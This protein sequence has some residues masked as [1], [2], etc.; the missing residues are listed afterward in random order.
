MATRTEDIVD[1]V[2][3]RF[4]DIRDSTAGALS[5]DDAPS[6]RELGRVRRSL[7]DVEGRLASRLD[8]LGTQQSELASE[9][10]SSNK[11]TT[12]P[13]KVFWMLIGG[14]AAALGTYLADPDRGA[15]RRQTLA[16]EARTRANR[17]SEQ[18]RQTATAATDEVKQRA[19]GLAE[20]AKSTATEVADDTRERAAHGAEVASGKAEGA[21]NQAGSDDVPED[22]VLLEQRVKSQVLGHR[23]DVDDVV[24][25]IGK[26]GQVILKGVVPDEQSKA[27]LVAAIGDVNGVTDVQSELS[28][29]N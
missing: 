12:F 6:L 16:D 2:A 9:V 26:P 5:S 15:Q 20:D 14:A 25:V 27:S 23:G 17:A 11:S 21:L 18:A 22:P 28:T 19:A 24:L 7:D 10:R 3:D 13:R 8:E 1:R 4:D 29:R